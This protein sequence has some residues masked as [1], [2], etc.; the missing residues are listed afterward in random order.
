[1]RAYL[2]WFDW[3][4][5]VIGLNNLVQTTPPTINPRNT[6]DGQRRRATDGHHG[7]AAPATGRLLALGILVSQSEHP[8]ILVSGSMNS[9]W[10]GLIGIGGH[11]AMA[12][13]PH[14]RAYGSVPRRFDWVGQRY[15][16]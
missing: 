7:G 6:A 8:P 14:H 3:R 9:V 2:D 15:E 5:F 11:L 10:C 4:H 12:L 13:L 16:E 1:M